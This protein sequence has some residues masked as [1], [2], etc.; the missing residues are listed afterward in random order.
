[1]AWLFMIWSV[2]IS[3]ASSKAFQI[4]VG[5]HHFRNDFL[6]LGR[7][8]TGA[9]PQSTLTR[10]SSGTFRLQ[11]SLLMGLRGGGKCLATSPKLQSAEVLARCTADGS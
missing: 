1:M 2:H 5:M 11:K 4:S 9:T 6:F 7:E 8:T 3:T 10:G